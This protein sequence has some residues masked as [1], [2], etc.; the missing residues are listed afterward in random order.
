MTPDGEQ[1]FDADG[2]PLEGL[3]RVVA[4]FIDL[5]GRDAV[6][7]GDLCANYAI[8]GHIPSLVVRPSRAVHAAAALALASEMHLAV[9]PWGGGTQMATGYALHRCDMVLS[10]ERLTAITIADP[11][12]HLVTV[13]GGCTVADV[14]VALAPHGQFLALDGPLAARATVG[15]RLAVGSLGLRRARYGNPRD[16]VVNLVIARSDGVLMHTSGTANRHMLQKTLGYDLNKLFVGSLGTLGIIV[17]ATLQTADLPNQ[18]AT[19][20]ASFDDP[21]DMWELCEDLTSAELHPAA[22]VVCGPGTLA[23]DRGLPPEFAA[24]LQPAAHPLLLARLMG[25]WHE[26]QR[27][28][29]TVRSLAM[30][31][32][33]VTPLFMQN[34]AMQVAWDALDDLPATIDL[35]PTEAVIKIAV[36][37]SEVGTVVDMARSLSAEH[38]LRLCWLCDAST[39]LIWLRVNGTEEGT[40]GEP[41]FAAALIGLQNALAR[42]WRNAMVLGCAPPLRHLLPLWGADPQGLDLL[43]VIKKRFDPEETLNPGRFDGGE[44]PETFR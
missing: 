19:V 14:N 9:I 7:A 42:R 28:A 35:L 11:T 39:G 6:L 8:D 38:G 37:P 40:I 27:Q 31:Y 13:Q 21:A 4:H 44:P 43:R 36:L 32:G 12:E 2:H 18:E 25:D 26:I 15:G 33:A 17:E 20:L 16:L 29:L 1:F 22:L 34:P 10:L 30:K 41:G 24:A 3:A 23:A 5:F